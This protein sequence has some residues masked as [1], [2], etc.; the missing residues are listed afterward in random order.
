MSLQK[1]YTNQPESPEKLNDPVADYEKAELDL[2]RNGIK[3]SFKERLLF[4]TMLY[5]V[6]KSFSKFTIIHKPDNLKK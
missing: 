5:K 3:R 2:L 6:Q 1:K 4:A